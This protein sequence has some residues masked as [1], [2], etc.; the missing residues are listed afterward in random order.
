M[1]LFGGEDVL[2]PPALAHP[3]DLPL[4]PGPAASAANHR[5]SGRSDRNHQGLGNGLIEPDQEIGSVAGEMEC[6]ERLSGLLKY[7]HRRTA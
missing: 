7:Y 2:S 3:A 5:V 6:R 4:R 1:N